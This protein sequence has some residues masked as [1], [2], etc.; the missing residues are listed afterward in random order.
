MKLTELQDDDK[1]AKKWNARKLGK[2]RAD[3]PLSR[4]SVHS[5]SHLLQANKQTSRQ[6]SCRL[7]IYIK[8]GDVGLV[9]QSFSMLFVERPL[10]GFYDKPFNKG[11]SY[12]SILVIV[13]E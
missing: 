9:F 12:N 10:H 8:R 7:F 4:P 6:S 3:A 11:E 2:Y 13:V 5:E 1:E